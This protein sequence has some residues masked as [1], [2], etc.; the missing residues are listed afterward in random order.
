MRA[1]AEIS[2]DLWLLAQRAPDTPLPDGHTFQRA[3]GDLLRRPGLRTVQHAGLLT[4]WGQ[5]AASGAAHELDAGARGSRTAYLIEAKA[6]NHIGKADLAVFEQKLTDYYFGRWQTVADHRWWS[7]LSS[8]G[9]VSE[10]ARRLACHRG[11]VLV[12]GRRLPLPVL[13]H[14]ATHHDAVGMLPDQL[15]AEIARLAPRAVTALQE[16]YVPDLDDNCLRIRPQPYTPEEID[17]LLW[18]QGEFSDE[19]LDY[20]ERRAPGRLEARGARVLELLHG[21][22]AA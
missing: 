12:D 14:H 5:R 19:I 16:R 9:D 22:R 17:D 15:C 7:I 10:A 8:A 4:L 3:I 1:L 13:L 20:Y 21:R 11:I 18:L 2:L 6:T